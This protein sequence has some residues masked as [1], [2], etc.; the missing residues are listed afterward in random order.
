MTLTFTG[1]PRQPVVSEVVRKFDV[2]LSI[3]GGSIED[4]AR[5]LGGP[6]A[7]G[8]GG[9]HDTGAARGVPA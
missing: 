8:A 3:L 5:G 9:R 6:V 2:D 7:R 4:L 1:D